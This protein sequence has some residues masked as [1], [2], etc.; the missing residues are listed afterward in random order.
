M[1]AASQFERIERGEGFEER[2]VA[3]S[4]RPGVENVK[5]ENE[6]GTQVYPEWLIA[7]NAR[8]RTALA[9]RGGI[10]PATG[11]GC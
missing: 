6:N 2:V 1:R 3:A 10:G 4:T 8:L 7:E 9:T 5:G 11:A